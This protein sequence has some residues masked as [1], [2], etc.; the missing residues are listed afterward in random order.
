MMAE[1]RVPADVAPLCSATRLNPSVQVLMGAWL[2]FS[3]AHEL[4]LRRN[5]HTPRWLVLRDPIA[6]SSQLRGLLERQ[7]ALAV[8]QLTQSPIAR[9]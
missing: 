1:P 7:P 9:A 6:L 8:V 5:R 2:A 3:Q 4:R